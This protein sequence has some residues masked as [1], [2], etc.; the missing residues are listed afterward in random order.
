M[1]KKN[2]YLTRLIPEPGIEILKKEFNVEINME[3]R[4]L[5]RKEF[6]KNIKG[7]DGVLCLLTDRIDEEVFK[8][9]PEVR[10]FANYAVGYDNIDVRKATEYKIPVSNTPDVLTDATAEMAWALLFAAAR[11]V[12]ESDRIMRSG[13]WKGW[14]PMQFIGGDIT[15]AVLGIVGAGRIGTAMAL[16][17]KGFKMKVLYCDSI[18]NKVLEDEVKGEKVSFEY[19]LENS[20]YISIHTPLIPETR[21]LFG[22][23]QFRK[24]KR[25]AYIINTARGPIIDEKSLVEAL[26]S[27]LIAGAGIDVYEK[28]PIA[29]P[30]LEALINVVMTPHTASATVSSRNGMAVKAALNL[31]AMV[32]GEVPQDCLNPEIYSTYLV[33]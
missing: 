4:P 10:G 17:S 19:I 1:S 25:T 5:E 16:K 6:L 29:E 22:I 23:E 8:T 27:G 20:D 15:G 14:G 31:I 2:V 21:H 33:V 30:E 7:K 26:K 9:V 3:D 32:K 13:K 12:V 11:R 28:E 24:M 18:A